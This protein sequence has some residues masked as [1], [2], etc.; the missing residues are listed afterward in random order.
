MNDQFNIH[1]CLP[2]DD[3]SIKFYRERD[4]AWSDFT[5][6]TTVEQRIAARTKIGKISADALTFI[7]D[8]SRRYA[9]TTDRN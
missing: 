7:R 3:E 5:S 4:G 9:P 6:A 2:L 1:P 8:N